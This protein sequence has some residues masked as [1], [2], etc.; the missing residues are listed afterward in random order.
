MGT[1]H[2]TLP[3]LFRC[4]PSKSRWFTF[5]A[6]EEWSCWRERFEQGRILWVLIHSRQYSI[7]SQARPSKKT[8]RLLGELF[9]LLLAFMHSRLTMCYSKCIGSRWTSKTWS[10]KEGKSLVSRI[11]GRCHNSEVRSRIT[12]YMT[13]II[14]HLERSL[15]TR[16]E[17]E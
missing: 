5:V 13:F 7:S 17:S 3:S 12:L 11:C 2:A 8:D 16:S 1:R 14:H 9:T 15:S 10:V 4:I 6:M